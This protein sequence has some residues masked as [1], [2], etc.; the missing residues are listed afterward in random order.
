MKAKDRCDACRFWRK[1]EIGKG[2]CH[3]NPPN[4]IAVPVG[5]PPEPERIL[6]A[7]RLGGPAMVQ[8]SMPQITQMSWWPGTAGWM[9]CGKFERE[10]D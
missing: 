2:E 9:S 8:P 10:E 6:A 3:F 7:K 1:S 5:P 4:S